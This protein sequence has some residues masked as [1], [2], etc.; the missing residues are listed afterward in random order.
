ME[1]VAKAMLR[2]WKDAGLC[3]CDTKEDN[4][5]ITYSNQG[6]GGYKPIITDLGAAYCTKV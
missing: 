3:L 2:L 1:Y 4:I 5:L 6:L